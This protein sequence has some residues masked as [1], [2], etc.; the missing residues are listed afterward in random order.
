MRTAQPSGPRVRGMRCRNPAPE[1]GL[2]SLD[3]VDD[4]DQLDIGLTVRRDL[5]GR[6]RAGVT[7]ALDRS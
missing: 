2:H 6:A 7:A 3:L 4:R 1:R 5:V